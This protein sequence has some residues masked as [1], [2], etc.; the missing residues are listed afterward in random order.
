MATPAIS[1]LNGLSTK[2]REIVNEADQLRREGNVVYFSDACR[3]FMLTHQGKDPNK[4]Y[5][6]REY[7]RGPELIFQDIGRLPQLTTVRDLIEV[8]QFHNL[9]YVVPQ[10]I[11][12]AIQYN[13]LND[14]WVGDFVSSQ[15]AIGGR[16]DEVPLFPRQTKKKA[17][18]TVTAAD[19]RKSKISLK[20]K[21]VSTDK[22]SHG[23]EITYDAIAH[24]TLDILAENMRIATDHLVT[25]RR[26]VMLDVL[27]DGET[28]KDED[29]NAVDESIITIGAT[30]K[31]KGWQYIDHLR[32]WVR[33]SALRRTPDSLICTEANALIILEM[34]EFKIR[35]Q[36][37]PEKTLR[38]RQPIPTAV[39]IYTSEKVTDDYIILVDRSS[40]LGRVF[41]DAP[42]IDSDRI[43]A[44]QIAE[45]YYW[46]DFGFFTRVPTARLRIDLT[47][48]YADYPFPATFY[49]NVYV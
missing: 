26:D 39:N 48:N 34:D 8:T 5:T 4:I 47:E 28:C 2:V 25:I 41:R 22:Y 35:A 36:G 40:V 10:V 13:I 7:E 17:T 18:P 24:M 19:P 23:F 49:P 16:S 42:R 3:N 1:L 44:K 27:I 29:G 6:E 30:D 33:M 43:V 12:D 46:E 15:Q 31:T 37:V 11:L 9:A 20:Q 21:S 45:T 32:G 14:D 38:L